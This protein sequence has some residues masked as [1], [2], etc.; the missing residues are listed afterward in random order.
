MWKG[1]L[2]EE[3]GS[4]EEWDRKRLNGKDYA[5][6]DNSNVLSEEGMRMET[7][8]AKAILTRL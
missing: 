2:W 4:V 3:D 6:V 5:N 7:Q 1:S 8:L